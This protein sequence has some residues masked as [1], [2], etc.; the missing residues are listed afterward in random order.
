VF[1]ALALHKAFQRLEAEVDFM[2]VVISDYHQLLEEWKIPSLVAPY[3][4]KN[5]L[6]RVETLSHALW[7]VKADALITSFHITAGQGAMAKLRQYNELPDLKSYLILRQFPDMAKF[8]TQSDFN[9][10]DWTHVFGIEPKV[11][12]QVQGYAAR[13]GQGGNISEVGP[14][15]SIWSDEV[16]SPAEARAELLAKAG[17]EDTGKPLMLICHNGIGPAET[18]D[19]LRFASSI[20]GDYQ[21]VVFSQTRLNS[22]IFDPEPIARYFQGVDHLVAA[23]GFTSFFE[24][25][26]YSRDEAKASWLP[27]YRAQ[28]D[29][30]AR[31][32]V[33]PAL[34]QWAKLQPNGAIT[35]ARKV[36]EDLRQ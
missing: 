6:D 33:E 4:T 14:T 24:W 31:V 20:E 13:Y 36:L 26:T 9:P 25:Q 27:V 30:A 2:A 7:Q 18:L 16:L 19:V 22:T 23:P 8:L 11:A 29:S 10:V 3:T 21:R 34:R 5:P 32:A 28:E 12:G 15:L 1:R 35:I 17:Q